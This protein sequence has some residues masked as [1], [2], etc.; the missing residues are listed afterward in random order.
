MHALMVWDS[1]LST[2]CG[3]AGAGIKSMEHCSKAEDSMR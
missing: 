2:F 1:D 3:T